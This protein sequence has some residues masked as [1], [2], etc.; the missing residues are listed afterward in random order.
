MDS[1]QWSASR[2]YL[3]AEP[4]LQTG[5]RS[6]SYFKRL[7]AGAALHRPGL[8]WGLSRFIPILNTLVNWDQWPV[9]TI[10]DEPA[11]SEAKVKALQDGPYGR[12][13]YF[14]DND[15][16]DHQVVNIEFAGGVTASLTV[17]GFAS[18]EGRWI[19]IEGTEGTLFG[20][21]TAEHQKIVAYD[22]HQV[23]KKVLL[24]LDLDLRGHAGGDDGLME[25]LLAFLE[26]LHP[27]PEGLDVLPLPALHWKAIL[28]PL[29]PT[30]R[31]MKTASLRWTNCAGRRRRDKGG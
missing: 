7:L 31:S 24:D 26:G 6:R 12:C 23:R 25:S 17:H 19:R 18:F 20:K 4:L 1:C 29:P 15:V 11:G 14:C 21:F 10:T 30:G 27:D 13:V 9:S 28:W 22:H 3:R 16:N 2:I 5:T 8:I